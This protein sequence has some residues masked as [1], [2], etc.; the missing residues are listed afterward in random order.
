MSSPAPTMSAVQVA[1]AMVRWG[2][3]FALVVPYRCLCVSRVR[4]LAGPA[5]LGPVQQV[6]WRRCGWAAA[7]PPGCFV[8]AWVGSCCLFKPPSSVLST[9]WPLL[10]FPFY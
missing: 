4:V 8:A 6:W 5:L 10:S 1:P 9:R 2:A 7:R 3:V